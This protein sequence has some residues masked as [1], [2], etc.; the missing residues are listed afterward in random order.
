VKE[1]I[2]RNSD[3]FLSLSGIATISVIGHSLKEIDFSY[4]KEVAKNAKDA[5]WVVCYRPEDEDH[6]IQ[7]L[8]KCG[9]Q[10]EKITVC[11]YAEV[12]G[13]SGS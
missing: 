6:H 5:K 13:T 10:E 8:L 4:F 7:K 12:Q 3:F 2:A 1:V 9:V 11:T